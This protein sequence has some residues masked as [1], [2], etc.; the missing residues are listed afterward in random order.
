MSTTTPGHLTTSSPVRPSN[1]GQ[2]QLQ[3]SPFSVRRRSAERSAFSQVSK[4]DLS[5]R[6]SSV[7]HLRSRER[8]IGQPPSTLLVNAQGNVSSPP[9]MRNNVSIRLGE[10]VIT[11]TSTKERMP[12]PAAKI[13]SS[14]N[15]PHQT[16]T[17]RGFASP[18]TPRINPSPAR[19]QSLFRISNGPEISYNSIGLSSPA[20]TASPITLASAKITKAAQSPIM[21]S[22][23]TWTPQATSI[24]SSSSSSSRVRFFTYYNERF[25]PI[26]GRELQSSKNPRIMVLRDKEVWILCEDICRGPNISLFLDIKRSIKIGGVKCP[27]KLP[28]EPSKYTPAELQGAENE[29]KQYIFDKLKVNLGDIENF[30]RRYNQSLLAEQLRVM[31]AMVMGKYVIARNETIEDSLNINLTSY[32][33]KLVLESKASFLVCRSN[34]NIEAGIEKAMPMGDASITACIGFGIGS[35]MLL[36]FKTNTEICHRALIGQEDFPTYLAG[37]LE[38]QKKESKRESPGTPRT[39]QTPANTWPSKF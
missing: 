11:F 17:P 30:L 5:K 7:G 16:R 2:Q 20:P 33:G 18:Y 34:L 24:G 32:D 1:Q 19:P 37:F 38:Y 9:R 10:V 4:G 8:P 35:A 22:P 39:P 15:M 21:R 3:P 23:S 25:L 27:L 6:H 28:E 29:L 31:N 12:P 14:P 13:G 26:E 36:G